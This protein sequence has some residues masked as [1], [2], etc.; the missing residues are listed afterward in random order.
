MS[1]DLLIN[2]RVEIKRYPKYLGPE[3][4]MPDTVRVRRSSPEGWMLQLRGKTQISTADYLTAGHA[5]ALISK[6][7]E[8]VMEMEPSVEKPRFNMFAR[9]PQEPW[10]WPIADDADERG[11][12]G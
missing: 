4:V 1:D 5:R 11:S 8:I 12:E 7:L 6:L 2:R 10:F 9:K 3:S